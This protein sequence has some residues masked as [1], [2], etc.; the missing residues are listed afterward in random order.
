M[1]L[2]ALL[3]LPPLLSPSSLPSSQL[4]PHAPPLTPLPSPSRAMPP[5]FPSL[6]PSYLLLSSF[7]VPLLPPLQPLLRSPLQPLQARGLG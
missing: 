7:L 2:P 4:S 5:Q 6:P 3:S 1:L